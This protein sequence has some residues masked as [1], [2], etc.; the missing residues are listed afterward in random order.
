MNETDRSVLAEIEAAAVHHPSPAPMHTQ[1]IDDLEPLDQPS[2]SQTNMDQSSSFFPE[3]PAPA[4]EEEPIPSP[5]APD[6]P[7]KYRLYQKYLT[8]T[9]DFF[10]TF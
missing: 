3:T 7:S 8:E 1:D 6:S 10:E 2:I 4:P 9:L 5:P